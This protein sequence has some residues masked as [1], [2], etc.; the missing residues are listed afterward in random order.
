M[1][2]S[3]CLFAVAVCDIIGKCPQCIVF[4]E[5]RTEVL[6]EWVTAAH[7][8]L[9]C[10]PWRS[11]AFSVGRRGSLDLTNLVL[12]C[13]MNPPLWNPKPDTYFHSLSPV[14]AWL[15]TANHRRERGSGKRGEKVKRHLV[16]SAPCL[17]GVFLLLKADVGSPDI[18]R[19]L[20]LSTES[21][22]LSSSWVVSLW[23]KNMVSHSLCFIV[24]P[25]I[26]QLTVLIAGDSDLI[27]IFLGIIRS[28]PKCGT[29]PTL[30]VGLWTTNYVS[31]HIHKELQV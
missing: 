23:N 21:C 10:K 20:C 3:V 5:W 25:L 6:N 24:R 8:I 29:T 2:R 12:L 31:I 16:A 17:L 18:H 9:W 14:T 1:Q 26:P 13:Q 4:V 30:A 15:H 28:D 27:Q 7:A 22:F 11:F 19:S